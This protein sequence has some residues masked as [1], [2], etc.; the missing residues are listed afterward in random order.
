MTAARPTPAASGVTPGADEPAG[1]RCAPAIRGAIPDGARTLVDRDARLLRAAGGGSLRVVTQYGARLYCEDLTG[2]IPSY[3]PPPQPALM[4]KGLLLLHDD[5]RL[6]LTDAGTRALQSYDRYRAA[7]DSLPSTLTRNP[8]LEELHR[9][10]ELIRVL[11]DALTGQ[12]I[13]PGTELKDSAG[14][15]VTYLGPTM[16]STDGGTSWSPAGLA[17]VR[18][19]GYGALPHFPAHLGAAYDAEPRPANS[20][21]EEDR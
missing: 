12:E 4:T 21:P 15:T 1:T 8:C 18:Y 19:T 9:A 17:R 16:S 6:T 2:S 5:G 10:D 20:R 11:R 7:A 13:P 14:H 3:L